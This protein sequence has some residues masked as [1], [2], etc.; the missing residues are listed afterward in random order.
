MS[1]IKSISGFRGTMGGQPGD[2]LTPL[3]IVK[4]TAAYV[5]FL[6]ETHPDAKPLKVIVGR[7]GRVSGPMLDKVV[8]G[9]LMGMGADV[10]DIGL[11]TTPTVE[12]EVIHSD[13]HGGIILTASHNPF[14]WNALKLLDENG[15]F[16]DAEAGRRVLELAAAEDFTFVTTE[17]LG[18][19]LTSDDAIRKHIAA[20]LALELVDVEAIRK[21]QFK[22]AFDAVNSTGGIALPMLLEALGVRQVVGMN[23]E[24][25]GVFAHNPEP[26]PEHL[27]E[28]CATVR[29][30]KADV[31]FVV[32]PDVDRLAIIQ[33]NG[34]PF[35][36]EYTLVSVADYVLQHTPGNTVSNL[37]S[38]RALQEVTEAR[39]G[40]YSASA[41]GEVNVVAQMKETGAVIGGEGNGGVIYPA[42]HY[43]RDALVGIAL[44]LTQLAHSGKSC[45]ELRKSYPEFVISKNRMDLTP[46]TDVD[47]LLQHIKEKYAGY[48]I[49][50]V[51]GV[52]I[53]FDRQWVHLRKSNTEP[54]I[55]IYAESGSAA[56]AEAL[57]RK[58]IG[59]I[60]S[61]LSK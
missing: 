35:V 14:N 6:Q 9:T 41:V 18:A 24:P 40:S 23:A 59:D 1:L 8:C 16:L 54:I 17:N 49:I 53:N 45:S 48:P 44:F 19:Y 5:M 50:D 7:D 38:T 46:G 30:E 51:D 10:L 34:E 52:R 58:I 36:E 12:M 61:Y 47:A 27:T 13:A 42:L 26:L 32:D 60:K 4:F 29:R 28:L 57:A 2:N 37:S 11:S 22:V 15:E 33:E 25:S 39:G 20:I 55:R 43:G 31:G 21:A 3:D 56:D